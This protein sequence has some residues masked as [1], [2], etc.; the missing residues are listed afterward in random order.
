MQGKKPLPHCAP[1]STHRF[2]KITNE[3]RSEERNGRNAVQGQGT[4]SSVNGPNNAHR[5]CN[6]KFRGR[7]PRNRKIGALI[8]H[9]PRRLFESPKPR[10]KEPPL[11]PQHD[12]TAEGQR[13]ANRQ[14]SRAKRT[15]E[16]YEHTDLRNGTKTIAT[17]TKQ[18]S[19]KRQ[20]QRITL[21]KLNSGPTP[22]R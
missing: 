13:T 19:P 1:R 8:A 16:L 7:K 22:K 21:A 20:N 2:T 4:D 15:N 3:S 5:K 17:S 10:N 11:N 18:D 9:G 6:T 14:S 12:K